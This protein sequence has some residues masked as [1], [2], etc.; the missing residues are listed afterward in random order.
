MYH[1]YALIINTFKELGIISAQHHINLHITFLI[2][3]N[4]DLITELVKR[5]SFNL[6]FSLH[7]RW[8]NK[9]DNNSNERFILYIKHFILNAVYI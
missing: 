6:M 7:L 1:T 4:T 3:F 2:L 5:V 8:K 9:Q